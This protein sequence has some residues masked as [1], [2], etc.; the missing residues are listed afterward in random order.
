MQGAISLTSQDGPTHPPSQQSI[1][2]STLPWFWLSLSLCVCVFCFLFLTFV[3]Q[4]RGYKESLH[5]ALPHFP[6]VFSLLP[7]LLTAK[8]R[9]STQ[10]PG[11]IL[12]LPRC[13]LLKST[14]VAPLSQTWKHTLPVVDI[15]K[16]RKGAQ[17]DTSNENGECESQRPFGYFQTPTR[18][19]FTLHFIPNFSSISSLRRLPGCFDFRPLVLGERYGPF[20][21]HA[22]DDSHILRRHHTQ[23]S[24]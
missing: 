12:H 20:P 4:L 21:A 10:Q 9:M 11:Q 17:Y 8:W 3:F 19:I 7:F 2:L 1:R 5:G 18:T 24:V 13:A 23:E 14:L 15:H 16:R 6:A 22:D